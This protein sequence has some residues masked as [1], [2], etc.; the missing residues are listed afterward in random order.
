[1]KEIGR[2]EICSISKGDVS[3]KCEWMD[4]GDYNKQD[5]VRCL[6]PAV[7]EISTVHISDSEQ[8]KE[9]PGGVFRIAVCMEHTE[10]AVIGGLN[11]LR[12]CYL[13]L[14]DEKEEEK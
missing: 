1:M 3:R 13:L 11:A 10:D 5:Y 4:R 12:G 6:N 8:G 9:R 14:S 7:R 2:I